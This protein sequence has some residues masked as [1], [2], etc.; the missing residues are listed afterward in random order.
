[1]T[2]NLLTSIPRTEQIAW[3]GGVQVPCATDLTKDVPIHILKKIFGR[4]S[5][6]NNWLFEFHL[7]D[8]NS[9]QLHHPGPTRVSHVLMAHALVRRYR[10]ICRAHLAQ[11]TSDDLDSLQISHVAAREFFADCNINTFKLRN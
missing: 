4:F 9:A 2:S 11:S 3:S 6:N 8:F 5:F 7:I 1:M 10:I